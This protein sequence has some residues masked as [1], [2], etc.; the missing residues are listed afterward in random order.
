MKMPFFL[1][2]PLHPDPLSY[3]HSSCGKLGK[4]V[5]RGEGLKLPSL[6]FSPLRSGALSRADSSCGKLGKLSPDFLLSNLSCCAVLRG[7]KLW[8]GSAS[9]AV[10]Q[11]Q[12]PQKIQ[13]FNDAR[14]LWGGNSPPSGVGEDPAKRGL[15]YHPTRGFCRSRSS[16]APNPG[17]G[18]LDTRGPGF[19]STRR[20]GS[21]GWE[22]RRTPHC[23]NR[24]MAKKLKTL[25]RAPRSLVERFPGSA[26][27]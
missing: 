25:A 14:K 7:F 5:F 12:F 22:N 26:R 11:L 4:T 3:A 23:Q 20:P 9:L 1:Y 16:A 6:L 17:T 2:S 19:L 10:P 27:R 24:E 18:H 13:R 21:P 8:K 15:P